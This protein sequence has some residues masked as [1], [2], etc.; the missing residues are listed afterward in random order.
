MSRRRIPAAAS[1]ARRRH[2]VTLAEL[3][4]VLAVL[5]VV[6][7]LTGV[8][9]TGAKPPPEPALGARLHSARRD[10]IRTGKAVTILVRR[11]A[12]IH[13]VTALPDGSALAD[14]AL[15]VDRAS[16]E[17]GDAAAR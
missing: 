10:A 7:A 13:R 9:F 15:H 16:G 12:R 8:A 6:G 11:D 4:V 2:G 1:R 5:A 14:T 3:M 17:V